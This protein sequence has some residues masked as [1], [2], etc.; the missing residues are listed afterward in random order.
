MRYSSNNPDFRHVRTASACSRDAA[1]QA[2]RCHVLE[3][4]QLRVIDLFRNPHFN[5]AYLANRH[6]QFDA[7]EVASVMAK[8]RRARDTMALRKLVSRALWRSLRTWLPSDINVC[9][10]VRLQTI[11]IFVLVNVVAKEY[12]VLSSASAA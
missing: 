8:A 5:P 9:G 10:V 2:E 7:G 12:L 3:E 11:A 1:T 4:K 6:E